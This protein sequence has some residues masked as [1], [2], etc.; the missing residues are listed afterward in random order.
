MP[1]T[2]SDYLKRIDEAKKRMEKE[3]IDLMLIYGDGWRDGNFRYFIG[4]A[5]FRAMKTVYEVPYGPFGMLAIPLKDEPVY[6]CCDMFVDCVKQEI[7]P[8][9]KEPW[10]KVEGWSRM[11]NILKGM[12]DKG[13]NSIALANM[14][15]IP[16]PIYMAVKDALGELKSTDIPVLMRWIKDEKEIKLMEK[17]AAIAD[18]TYQD[19]V[20]YILKP[21]K[22]EIDISREI[23]ISALS[24]G[25]DEVN[26]DILVSSGPYEEC[27]LG[28]S[29]DVPIKKGTL[30]QFHMTPRY[31][32]YCSDIDRA[33]GFGK[34]SKEQVELLEVAKEAHLTGEKVMRPGIKGS[35]ILNAAISVNK[36][37]VGTAPALVYGHGIGLQF[38]EVGFIDDWTMEPGMTFTFAAG[39]YK[40]GVGAVRIEDVCTITN[41][42]GRCLSRFDM[43]AI[44]G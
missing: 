37:L 44:T 35:E 15:I 22:T 36:E 26:S 29:R 31:Q 7:E 41:S 12:K 9:E 33:I 27:R 17:A 3:G 20:D 2:K 28:K 34:L 14:D 11:L 39:T 8:V 25:A 40:K 5:P 24:H 1:I 43:D 4:V 21:G 6:F 19:V 16:Y 30:L 23:I 32:G 38:E 13:M 42:G 18:M 10:I